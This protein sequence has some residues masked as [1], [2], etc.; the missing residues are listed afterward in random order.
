M[1]CWVRWWLVTDVSGHT[2]G[3]ISKDQ[4]VDKKYFLNLEDGT[5]TFS[6][7]VSNYERT[8]PSMTSD[9]NYTTAETWNVA[10][11]W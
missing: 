2:T 10:M 5:D 3:N 6:R 11:F 7:N 8:P 9:L 1:L 4:A